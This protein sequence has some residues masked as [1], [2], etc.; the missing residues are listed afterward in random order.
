MSILALLTH[1]AVADGNVDFTA[2]TQGVDQLLSIEGHL[3]RHPRG[4][5][6]QRLLGTVAQLALPLCILGTPV[7]ALDAAA[8]EFATCATC[9]IAARVEEVER[10]E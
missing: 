2:C 4:G 5:V 8:H 1:G 9:D 3:F 7:G 10:V 6:G